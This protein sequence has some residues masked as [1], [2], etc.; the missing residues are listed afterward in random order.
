MDCDTPRSVEYKEPKIRVLASG[1]VITEDRVFVPCGSCMN[2][3][4]N[5]IN[6]WVFRL[7]QEMKV[8]TDAKFITLT[9]A[10]PYLP[11][12]EPDENGEIFPTLKKEDL[13]KFFKR[14]RKQHD[15]RFGKQDLKLVKNGIPLEN[16]PIKYYAVG[17]YGT[18]EEGHRPHYHAILFNC[19]NLEV[20]EDAWGMGIVDSRKVTTAR[21]RYVAGYI[22][23]SK[24]KP[25]P[26]SNQ[27]EQY[28]VMSQGLGK[29]YLTKETLEAISKHGLNYVV[30]D[31]GHKIP[32]PRYYKD[33]PVGKTLEQIERAKKSKRPKRLKVSKLDQ[34][35]L[36]HQAMDA[37]KEKEK[38]LERKYGK[39][40]EKLKQS[41]KLARG[42]YNLTKKTRK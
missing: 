11:W 29:N 21:M 19:R 9:Y 27:L 22:H 40:L 28:S 7:Q 15:K 32:L 13:Q 10:D 6:Q 41:G 30:N 1:H 4:K 23:T 2:C 35:K 12:T 36:K 5:R 8:S 3:K 42:I 34:I 37:R 20:I 24:K 33:Q 16:K 39:D 25:Y 18:D 17:E 26:D 38:E 31:D 14:L